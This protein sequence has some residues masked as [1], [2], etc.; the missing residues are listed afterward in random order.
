MY[1]IYIK[2]KNKDAVTVTELIEV[3]PFSQCS[4]PNPKKSKTKTGRTSKRYLK[5]V[6]TYIIND[7]KLHQNA[8][9]QTSLDEFC[10]TPINETEYEYN[11]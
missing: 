9:I 2:Y 4:P 3:K 5:E 8:I 10:M 1:R 11:F 6:N 7:A